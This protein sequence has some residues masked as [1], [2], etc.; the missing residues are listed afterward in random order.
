MKEENILY[1]GVV[2]ALISGTVVLIDVFLHGPL[3]MLVILIFIFHTV[4]GITGPTSF[5]LAMESQGNIFLSTFQKNIVKVV[6][7]ID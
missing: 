3:K 7:S 5:T 2:L 4:I 1:I 6:I